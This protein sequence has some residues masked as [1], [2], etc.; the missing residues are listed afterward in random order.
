MFW[1]GTLL[2]DAYINLGRIPEAMRIKE[3]GKSI[4]RGFDPSASAPLLETLFEKATGLQA[5]RHS[6]S[7]QRGFVLAFV[8]LCWSISHGF[9]GTPFG[10]ALLERLRAF[11]DSYGIHGDEWEWTV[12]HAHLTGYDFVGLLSILLHH[13]GLA[14][15]PLHTV[16]RRR[17]RVIEVR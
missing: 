15:T 4:A 14:P 2:V 9:Q 6:K 1:A 12:K 7:R 8:P 10:S 13:T 5:K 3:Q 16:V 11:F 17:P